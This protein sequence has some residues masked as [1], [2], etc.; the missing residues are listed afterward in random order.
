PTP[1]SILR[2][3]FRL[4]WT[5]DA[6]C[7]LHLPDRR[8]SRCAPSMPRAAL[9]R[10]SSGLLRITTDPGGTG[11]CKAVGLAARTVA[12]LRGNM[13]NV[14]ENDLSA[15]GG[16]TVIRAVNR[17]PALCELNGLFPSTRPCAPR[18]EE[19]RSAA[20]AVPTPYLKWRCGSCSGPL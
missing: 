14:P 3:R 1:M 16:G 4:T 12:H 9:P 11:R 18:P 15:G 19:D 8:I 2:T 20:P 13:N 6:A 10:P 5:R 17:R 7:T